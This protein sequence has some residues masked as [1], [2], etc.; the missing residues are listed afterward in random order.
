MQVGCSHAR[1]SLQGGWE[2]KDTALLPELLHSGTEEPCLLEGREQQEPAQTHGSPSSE[3]TGTAE[4]HPA[5]GLAP[6]DK[7]AAGTTSS[8]G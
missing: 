7:D 4:P 8:A 6:G 5:A 1:D 2:R 3:T